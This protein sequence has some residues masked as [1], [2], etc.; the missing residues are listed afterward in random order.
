M[1]VMALCIQSV[2]KRLRIEDGIPQNSCPFYKA[3]LA[4]N[5]KLTGPYRID[6]TSPVE[7][8]TWMNYIDRNNGLFINS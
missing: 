2:L 8:G 4:D 6:L 3:I 7:A 1:A 5:E